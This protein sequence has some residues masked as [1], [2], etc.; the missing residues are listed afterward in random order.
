[1]ITYNQKDYISNCIDS[2]LMQRTNFPIE[3]VIGDDNSTDG[4]REIIKNYAYEY[5]DIIKLNLREKRGM[6]LPG[7][8]NFMT[9]LEMCSG[10]YISLCEGDDYWT[11]PYKLQKQ[12]DFLEANQ[13]CN[14]C[15]HRANML[16]KGE[17]RLHQM[18]QEFESKPF[19][20][21]ELLE[22][23]NFIMTASVVFRKP[24]NF[25]LP[26]WF[27]TMLIGDMSLYKIV[28][29]TKNI[30]CLPE[31]MSVYRIHDKGVWSG[32]DQMKSKKRYLEFYRSI[33]PV[34][35][36]NE[37]KVVR[38]K[39]KIVKQEIARLKFPQNK[40]LSQIYLKYF[41]LKL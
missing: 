30:Y 17:L 6:G 12:V 28:S 10:E 21:I 3:I 11:D 18:P 9:T 24:E 7:K 34:L 15:F 26:K 20:Y 39:V 27:N 8:Q 5:P 25:Y 37:K 35:D 33:F 14:I 32:M 4:T 19:K 13:D 2:I 29:G 36:E 41:S 23:F 22:Y 40:F 31:I 38:S 1:M 16:E